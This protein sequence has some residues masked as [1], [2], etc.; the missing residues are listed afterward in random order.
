MTFAPI[1]FNTYLAAT[2]GLLLLAGC[3]STAKKKEKS[4]LV[5]LEFHLEVPSNDDS[6]P[7]SPVPVYREKP[8]YVNVE[9]DAFLDERYLEAARVVEDAS[10]YAIQLKFFW[11]GLALLDGVT[12]INRNRRMAV[13]CVFDKESR[14]LAA[15][16]IR[17]PISSGVIT[18]TPDAS[19]EEAERIV[20]GLN[21]SVEKAEKQDKLD[22]P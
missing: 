8:V 22:K 15:P 5:H 7:S 19:R 20:R 11:Q 12:T 1:R 18:F 16:V 13:L 6:T 14:W 9:K 17:Q 2:L 3:S 10:G 4:E 21:A